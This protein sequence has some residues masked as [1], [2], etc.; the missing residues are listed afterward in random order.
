MEKDKQRIMEYLEMGNLYLEDKAVDDAINEFKK[1]F[2][3]D[4]KNMDVLNALAYS[5]FLKCL[6][7][8]R[9]S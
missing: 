3:I 5:H 8:Q 6:I 9:K 2:E 1:A 7:Q 4:K